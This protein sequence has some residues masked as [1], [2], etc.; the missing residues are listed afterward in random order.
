MRSWYAATNCTAQIIMWDEKSR[1]KVWDVSSMGGFVYSMDINP[2]DPAR[3]VA[4]IGDNTIRVCNLNY[5]EKYV[6]CFY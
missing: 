6:M 2:T 4:A 5:T 3:L 1:Q